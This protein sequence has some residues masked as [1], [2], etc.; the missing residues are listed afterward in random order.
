MFCFVKM[1][2]VLLQN[3]HDKNYTKSETKQEINVEEKK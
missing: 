3:R 1:F 2:Q